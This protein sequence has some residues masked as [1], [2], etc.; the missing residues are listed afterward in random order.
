MTKQ[1]VDTINSD[2]DLI[3]L[4]REIAMDINP[5]ETILKSHAISDKTWSKLQKNA[6]FAQLVAQET[7]QWQ[8]ALNTQER[9]KVKSAAMLEQWLPTLFTRINSTDEALPGV[10]EAGKM[11]SRLAG[12]GGSGEVLANVGER[13]SITINMG[14]KVVEFNK[15]SPRI[16]DVTPNR[17]LRFGEDT[18]PTVST[19]G[20]KKEHATHFLRGSAIATEFKK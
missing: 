17:D 4:A 2:L 10:V 11:L 18:T 15:E 14:P 8:T 5:L 6:R 12:L 9:V 19:T 16:V 3:A 7:E 1:L 13:F 20:D